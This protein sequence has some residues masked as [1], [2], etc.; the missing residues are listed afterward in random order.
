MRR[1]QPQREARQIKF[2]PISHCRTTAPS[3]ARPAVRTRGERA[4]IA[5][6]SPVSKSNTPAT[7]AP[8]RC[9]KWMA[10]RAACGK[11]PPSVV[12]T[13]L[14]GKVK[15]VAEIGHRMIGALAGGE[16][17]AGHGRMIRAGPPTQKQLHHQRGEGN[18]RQRSQLRSAAVELRASG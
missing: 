13:A 6:S 15:G 5:T 11:T 17:R 14:M 8:I 2:I 7:T 1:P 12:F 16:I 10:V 4:R 18:N 3:N 9:V